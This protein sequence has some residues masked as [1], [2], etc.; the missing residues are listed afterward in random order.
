MKVRTR[1]LTCSWLGGEYDN[2]DIELG[3]EK[4]NDVLGNYFSE[5]EA[6]VQGL[7]CDNLGLTGSKAMEVDL[8]EAAPTTGLPDQPMET[9]LEASPETF[10]PELTEQRYTPSLFSSPDLPPSLV[11]PSEDALL[12]PPVSDSPSQDQSKAPGSGRMEGSTL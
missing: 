8:Q 4:V 5:T 6:A 12:D 10:R 1:I 9:E 11:T 3:K 7:I 2:L